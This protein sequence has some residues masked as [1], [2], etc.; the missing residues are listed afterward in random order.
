MNN[1]AQDSYQL[2]IGGEWV[3]VSDGATLDSFCPATGEKLSTIADA[4]RRTLIVRLKLHG[5]HLRPGV[6]LTRPNAL[7]S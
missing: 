2:Y 3:N 6:K 4:T 7:L 1:P 5:R